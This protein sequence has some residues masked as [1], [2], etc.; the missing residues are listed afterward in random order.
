M[1]IQPLQS[2]L[3]VEDYLNLEQHSNL[4]HEYIAGQ[5]YAMSGG[6]EA[7]DLISVNLLTRLRT[8]LRGSGCRVFSGNMKVKIESLD[9]F[10]Y[11]D[12]SVTCDLQDR[13]KYFKTRPCSIVEVLSPNTERVDRHEKWNNYRQLDSLQ[14]YVLVSQTEMKVEI[15]RRGDRGDWTRE[16][17]G[18][19]DTIQFAAVGL[20]MTV[21]EIYEEVEL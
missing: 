9:L 11:P 12:V 1:S 13:E 14:E 5:V 6:S 19:A 18:P 16:I 8:H 4:R 17:F 20:E 2:Y 7:H 10:Y 15:Y 3:S 21:A